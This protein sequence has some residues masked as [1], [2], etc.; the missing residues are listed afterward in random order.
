EPTEPQPAQVHV[1]ASPCAD[2]LPPDYPARERALSLEGEVTVGATI[3]RSGIVIAVRLIASSAHAG[4]DRA[5][6][7]AVRTWRF[8]PATV[9]GVPV[10]EEM[11]V[12]IE[13]RLLDRK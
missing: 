11:P 9:D 3:D 6:L 2:N 12:T 7:A 1:A 4:F 10:A 5:A 8:E 13:F